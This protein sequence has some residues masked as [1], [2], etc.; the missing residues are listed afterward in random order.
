MDH[1][2]R[3]LL[4]KLVPYGQEI[5]LFKWS[6]FA[7]QKKLLDMQNN[8]FP[9]FLTFKSLNKALTGNLRNTAQKLHTHVHFLV[10]F[11]RT[12]ETYAT[13]PHDIH[14]THFLVKFRI[15]EET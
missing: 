12:Q 14:M 7:G 4:L 6:A 11:R 9:I 5:L 1:F 10:K 15:I 8:D 2:Y 3:Q 13:T